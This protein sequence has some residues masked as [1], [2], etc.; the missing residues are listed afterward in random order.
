LLTVGNKHSRVVPLT[1]IVIV[2]ISLISSDYSRASKHP[3]V[4]ELDD[5]VDI[6]ASAIQRAEKSRAAHPA[7][8]ADLK[9]ILAGLQALPKSLDELAASKIPIH[10]S[11]TKEIRV[12]ASTRTSEKGT[13]ETS[14]NITEKTTDP[15]TQK[16]QGNSWASTLLKVVED[17]ALLPDLI[18]ELGSAIKEIT[19]DSSAEPEQTIP[20][21]TETS[22]PIE[23]PTDAGPK[24]AFLADLAEIEQVSTDYAKDTKAQLIVLDS[25]VAQ[26]AEA[27]HEI[28]AYLE[29]EDPHVV[30]QAIE[31]L[32]TLGSEAEPAVPAL[33]RKLS[34]PDKN[35]KS[36]I[37]LLAE[38][39]PAAGAAVPT[40]IQLLDNEDLAPSALA[41]LVAINTNPEPWAYPK[42]IRCL[43]L[44]SDY[45]RRD[46]MTVLTRCGKEAIPTL[47]DALNT[48]ND[49]IRRWSAYILGEM[50]Y[51][52]L[53]AVKPLR[54]ASL[55]RNGQVRLEA[56]RAL[57]KIDPYDPEIAYT[58]A[59]AL[60]DEE[61]DVV[62]EAAL[63][64]ARLRNPPT[65]LL[66]DLLSASERYQ[67]NERVASRLARAIGIYG[68][69][70]V[71]TLMTMVERGLPGSEAAIL[72][73]GQ[74]G[75]E[76]DAATSL[77]MN[78]F[79]GSDPD[80]Q[81]SILT[82][83]GGIGNDRSL[84]LLCD[85]Y[86]S[87]SKTA[88]KVAALEAISEFSSAA[89]TEILLEALNSNSSWIFE[90]AVS[91][92]SRE[93]E[94]VIDLLC[95][96]LHDPDPKMRFAAIATL[97]EMGI[98]ATPALPYIEE[99]MEQDPDERVRSVAKAGM[100]QIITLSNM[101]LP[102]FKMPDYGSINQLCELDWEM[103]VLTT[104]ELMRSI[105]GE[106]SPEETL[107]FEKEWEPF[108]RY[109]SQDMVDYLKKLNPLLMQFTALRT[110]LVEAAYGYQGAIIDA[111]TAADFGAQAKLQDAL[112]T[113]EHNMTLIHML[114]REMAIMA[115]KIDELGPLPDPQE[116]QAKA[117]RRLQNALTVTNTTDLDQLERESW[118]GGSYWVLASIQADT[119]R[120]ISSIGTLTLSSGPPGTVESPSSIVEGAASGS[121]IGVGGDFNGFETSGSVSWTP[122]PRLLPAD[123]GFRF[124]MKVQAN[125]STDKPEREWLMT[126]PGLAICDGG[127]PY[128]RVWAANS[129]K[130][131]SVDE[132]LSLNHYVSP[133]E[134]PKSGL[135]TVDIV[136]KVVV[137]GAVGVFKHTYELRELDTDQVQALIQSAEDEKGR[138]KAQIDMAAEEF[139]EQYEI[140]HQRLSAV[141]FQREQAQY[142]RDQMHHLRKSLQ[143]ATDTQ[144]VENLT[145][146]LMVTEA[147]HQGALDEITFAETGEWT[148][149]PTTYDSYV[150]LRMAE[151]GRELADEFAERTR[152]LNALPRQL[153]L[154]PPDLKE[155]LTQFVDR[156]LNAGD[157]EQMRSVARIV[158]DRVQAHWEGEAARNQEIAA[159]QDENI[160]WA[161]SIKMGAGMMLTGGAS[162]AAT[163]LSGSARAV[164]MA[165]TV[166]RMLYAGT[167]GYIEGGPK[168]AIKQT[169]AWS[170]QVGA[171]AI[172]AYEGF[173]AGSKQGLEQGVSE[174]AWRV[175]QAYAMGKI[176]D[177]GTHLAG[178]AIGWTFGKQKPSLQEQFDAARYQEEIA[179]AKNLVKHW[180]DK[181]WQLSTLSA[182]GVPSARGQQ[183]SNELTQLVSSINSSYHAKW[184]LKH[185]SP[186]HVQ[187]LFNS[188]LDQVYSSTMPSFYQQLETLGYDTKNL[189]FCTMRNASNAGSVG[190]DLDLALDETSRVIISKN[191]KQ[192][193]RF[194]FMDDAQ[195]AWN[196]AY[197]QNTGYSA[198][199][200]DILITTK[201]HPEA[202]ADTAL[203][204]RN[205]DFGAI[206]SGHIQQAGDVFRTKVQHS[207]QSA[208]TEIGQTQAV[209]RDI[210]K[211]MRTKVLPY[212]EHRMKQE[213]LRGNQ[214]N[215]NKLQE[216]T[217]Y[218]Q[219]VYEKVNTIGRQET[220]PYKI[221]Q[222]GRELETM[223][224]HKPHEVMEQLAGHFET[225][226]KF[227]QQ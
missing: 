71:P 75:S 11:S 215:V 45:S 173:E 74:I 153:A 110:A 144:A 37:Q 210:E 179:N 124:P 170:H 26:G 226:G 183:V 77:L 181:Q 212:M 131:V 200:S 159:I 225:L 19:T 129:A 198:V 177:Y 119:A 140:A 9:E 86:N 70:A 190:M 88:I 10:T 87:G 49:T 41:A 42:L 134:N 186:P 122:L 80:T 52:A 29:S 92:L 33:T 115:S 148:R 197:M 184:L 222:M 192:V 143:I 189:H 218:W 201:A 120:T 157:L 81:E 73:L 40:L 93:G 83:L 138:Q 193:S 206:K 44:P 89:S 123:T 59:A 116:L 79:D 85:A 53:A 95:E 227:Y 23:A 62:V 106:M 178:R 221:R 65:E 196:R 96:M 187:A 147:N 104:M 182:S 50:R 91:G 100:N 61:E 149:T 67:G 133:Y 90:T 137:P 66:D 175:G 8:L 169:I 55:D 207:L 18:E 219:K 103:A 128:W 155:N 174:A 2:L 167:T 213:A 141:A 38:L 34:I 164:A 208:T 101:D 152:I 58:I 214:V 47:V 32:E 204:S 211:E 209:C 145:W 114:Q 35:S 22:E 176:M 98:R 195:K 135:N 191:G 6:L 142:F 16:G 130:S 188:R 76:A 127:E 125:F 21:N 217:G 102:T 3:L 1:V 5:T 63:S 216:T 68:A 15:T 64:M 108:F 113:A 161:Q 165:P 4:H 158:S 56:I 151:Q 112:Y 28:A 48:G 97:G 166:T 156:N 117:R 126:T 51:K 7:F 139:A 223:T 109:P 84:E 163:A 25:L 136:V 224:G 36:I 154:A 171:L 24:S 72:A 194:V 94:T 17:V 27:I 78:I 205:I 132:E 146:Q 180:Q 57:S 60:K 39:G 13:D 111:S 82:A 69:A 99:L 199:Q 168:E 54:L 150:R 220:N 31:A 46:A 185:Q 20:T 43:E 105:L 162:S 202:F 14:G 160:F 118:Q 172:E 203:L 12:E 30:C 121:E 107:L